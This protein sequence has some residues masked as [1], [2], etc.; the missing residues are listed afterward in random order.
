VGVTRRVLMGVAIHE[1][2]DDALDGELAVHIEA[3]L[4][5]GAG[6]AH[7]PFHGVDH[8]AVHTRP[9]RGRILG[10]DAGAATE[11][12]GGGEGLVLE[13]AFES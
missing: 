2:T 3:V 4:G 10:A 9:R 1:L 12:A 13:E 5:R 8:L 11:V 6:S 7:V